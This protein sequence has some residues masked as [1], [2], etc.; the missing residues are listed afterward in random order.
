MKQPV[1]STFPFYAS[2]ATQVVAARL[3]AELFERM[4][5]VRRESNKSRT[6]LIAEALERFLQEQTN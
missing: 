6:D 4:E 1:Y 2:A 3:S 5:M